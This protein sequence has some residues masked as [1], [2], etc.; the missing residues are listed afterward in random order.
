MGFEGYAASVNT[1]DELRDPAEQEAAR[2]GLSV[3]A[4]IE[5]G[6]LLTFIVGV[7]VAMGGVV[8][9]I[10][11]EYEEGIDM[12]PAPETIQSRGDL[13]SEPLGYWADI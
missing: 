12:A 3:R 5:R 7:S 2:R 1:G 4:L 13:V 10:I 6:P 11:C 8:E 9:N